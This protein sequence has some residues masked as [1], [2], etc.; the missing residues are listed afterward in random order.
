MRIEEEVGRAMDAR[1]SAMDADPARRQRIRESIS[2]EE[3][4]VKKKMTIGLA[5]ALAALALMGAALAAGMNVFEYFAQRDARLAPLVQGVAPATETPLSVQTEALGTSTIRFDSAYYDGQNLLVGIVLENTEYIEPFEPTEAQLADM[6]KTARDPMPIPVVG[7]G[8]DSVITAFNEA[9]SQGR[10]Y[11]FTECSVYPS[12]HITTGEGVDVGPASGSQ[13]FS[14]EG[15][16]LEL[17]EMETPLPDEI[18]NLDGLELHLTIWRQVTRHWFDGESEY[19]SSERVR[20]GEAVC[21]VNRSEA[22][23]ISLSG[24]GEYGGVPVQLSLAVSALHAELTVE[25]EGDAFPAPADN[26]TWYDVILVDENGNRLRE[27]ENSAAADRIC[28]AYNGTGRLPERV[29]AY[30]VVETEGDWDRDEAMR[31]AQPVELTVRE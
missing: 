15:L 1:L 8:D 7:D 12:D 14:D 31:A 30:I 9:V 4:S 11:G 5:F 28:A 26:D 25:A 13:A 16:M 17:R 22:K 19:V 27:L 6:E 3:K 23:F 20:A 29:T 18:Q 10:P 24:E 2:K 21:T